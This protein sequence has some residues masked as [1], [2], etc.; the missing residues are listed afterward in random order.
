MMWEMAELYRHMRDDK[1]E[2]KRQDE[3]DAK[4]AK[5]LRN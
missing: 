1:F 2:Q 5:K 3:I 4:A